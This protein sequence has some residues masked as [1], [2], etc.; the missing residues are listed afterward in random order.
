MSVVRARLRVRIRHEADDA[1]KNRGRRKHV[2]VLRI[3][4]HPRL[5]HQHAKMED[6]QGDRVLLPILRAAIQALF[7]PPRESGDPV[8]AVREAAS[9]NRKKRCR[10][11]YRNPK[12]PLLFGL[13]F[14][15]CKDRY[16]AQGI[17][18]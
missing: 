9:W 7:K 16:R 3:E 18:L 17:P 8:F 14:A 11:R 5:Q 6:E 10:C 15:M 2:L 1:V 13:S 12:N 4:W